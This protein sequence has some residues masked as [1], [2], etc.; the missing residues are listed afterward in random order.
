M[1]IKIK[2]IFCRVGSKRALRNI[3]PR[4]FP[5][6]YNK[7]VEPFVGG[8]AIFFYN[9]FSGKKIVLND[10]DKDLMNNYKKIK[11]GLTG[12]ISKYN[13]TDLNYLKQ[14]Y[15]KTGGTDMDRFVRYVL[16]SCNTFG[17]KGQGNPLYKASNPFMKLKNLDKYQEKLSGASLLNKDYKQVIKS[18]DA[19]DTLFYLDPPYE[20]STGLYK[21]D[22]LNLEELSNLLK[23]IK[24]KFLLS[25]ND[26]ANTRKIFSP[27][28]IT[29]IK[30][31]GQGH[32]EN[33][34]IGAGTRKEL[35]VRN[36]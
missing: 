15:A 18:N 26:S 13:S 8:G 20:D 36:Y 24:G 21:K 30:V 16:E 22:Q 14:I 32:H 35:L 33:S 23:G 9:D 34:A 29:K 19:V 12:D 31:K 7:Y 2:P 3:V 6:D 10:L 11:R 5:K 25:V 28:K 1:D 17:S 27:F 4:Y